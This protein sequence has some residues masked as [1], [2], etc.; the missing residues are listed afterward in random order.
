MFVP[1]LAIGLMLQ[2][3][4]PLP[5]TESGRVA[6]S[7]VIADES[8]IAKALDLN[9]LARWRVKGGRPAP[10]SRPLP[11]AEPAEY[12]VEASSRSSLTYMLPP[13]PRTVRLLEVLPDPGTADAWRSARLRIVWESDN[14][15]V[16]RSSLDLPLGLAFAQAEGG[17]I[18]ESPAFASDGS[19]WVNRLPMPYRNQA[20]LRIDTDRPLS[21][22]LRLK[23]T[24]GVAS[25]AGYLRAT[26][27]R[28]G[29]AGDL[30]NESGRGHV[31]GLLVE[32]EPGSLDLMNRRQDL[33]CLVLDEK[34]VKPSPGPA[35]RFSADPPSFENS[36]AVVSVVGGLKKTKATDARAILF[37]YSDRPAAGVAETGAGR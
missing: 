28:I 27:W 6:V 33:G 21:G 15:V 30:L 18:G 7:A 23:A 25:D 32:G 12:K 37:W 29:A 9:D 24:R 19:A 22:R 36:I 13:G 34:E 10:G 3:P 16:S 20:L 35:R 4:A 14:P 1:A 11:D 26:P 31:V 5:A 2:A 17:P 8:G